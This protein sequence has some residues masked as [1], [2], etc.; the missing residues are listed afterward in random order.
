[1]KPKLHVRNG[2]WLGGLD[3]RSLGLAEG[4]GHEAPR[5]HARKGER[6]ADAGFGDRRAPST[7]RTPIAMHSAQ[8][9]AGEVHACSVGVWGGGALRACCNA[10]HRATESLQCWSTRIEISEEQRLDG[11]SQV[12]RETNKLTHQT[13]SAKGLLWGP[14]PSPCGSRRGRW[15]SGRLRARRGPGPQAPASPSRATWAWREEAGA[16]GLVAQHS[17]HPGLDCRWG[18][19]CC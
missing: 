14:G 15:A 7:A 10:V 18:L 13:W 8:R 11:P 12:D 19:C 17:P 4:S 3:S 5:H 6:K 1:M 9:G 16:H 2:P